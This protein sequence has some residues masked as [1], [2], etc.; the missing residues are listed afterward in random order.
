[1]LVRVVLLLVIFLCARLGAEESFIMID[2]SSG[3]VFKTV[4]ANVEER[5]SPCSTFK[6]ALSLMGFHEGILIDEMQPLWPYQEGYAGDLEMWRREQT[7]KS[8]LKCSC[9]WY[10]RILTEQMGIEK[11]N[12][13]L[14]DFSYGNQDMTGDPG[15]ENGLT[16]AWLGSSLQISPKEQVFFLRKML[17]SELCV[18]ASTVEI[19]KKLL[20]VEELP[21]GYSLYGKTGLCGSVGWFVGWIE[22]GSE[23]YVFAYRIQKEPIDP[24]LRIPRA[25][26]LL[27]NE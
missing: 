14:Q 17:Q 11:I 13:Y 21:N 15:Q 7:P 26:Q 5:A 23:R 3:D 8:W 20:F 24:S 18:S 2:A 25:K 16:N 27:F 6:I 22:K 12:A 19:T 10:S 1:M 9:I 4:G